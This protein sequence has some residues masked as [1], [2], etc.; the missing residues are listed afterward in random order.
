MRQIT[1]VQHLKKLLHQVTGLF[2]IVAVRAL[3]RQHLRSSATASVTLRRKLTELLFSFYF[4]T[5]VT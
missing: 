2:I 1:L 3:N 5:N 4:S